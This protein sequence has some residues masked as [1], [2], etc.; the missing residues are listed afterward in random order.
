MQPP[1]KNVG[2]FNTL[3]DQ[4]Y[5]LAR[6]NRQ[7]SYRTRERYFEAGRRDRHL[8]GIFETGKE[9][10]AMRRACEVEKSRLTFEVA[11]SCY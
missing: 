1:V 5:K 11:L 2:G 7:G 8:P 3:M 10:N 9:V 6:H 4:L